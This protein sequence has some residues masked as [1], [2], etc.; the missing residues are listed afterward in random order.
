MVPFSTRGR[1]RTRNWSDVLAES[2]FRVEGLP[3]ELLKPPLSNRIGVQ[4]IRVINC[5]FIFVVPW[6]KA[7]LGWTPEVEEFATFGNEGRWAVGWAP[8]GYFYIAD[9]YHRSEEFPAPPVSKSSLFAT[10]W[11]FSPT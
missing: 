3:E 5:N 8:G 4:E 1:K 2:S 10:L 11:L 7:P 9:D 6:Y